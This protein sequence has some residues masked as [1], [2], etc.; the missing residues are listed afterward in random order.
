[1]R[2]T[3]HLCLAVS[4]LVLACRFMEAQQPKRPQI[5]GVEHI[6]LWAHDYEKSRAFYG[7]FLGF[8]ESYSLKNADGSPAVTFFKINDRQYI[9]L[10][11]EHEAGTDRLNHMGLLTDDA[12]GMRAYLAAKGYTVPAQI[13]KGRI[14][15]LN[16]TFQDPEGHAVEVVQYTPDSWPLREKGKHLPVSRIS[17]RMMHVGIIVTKLHDEMVFYTDV[18]GF[19]EFW[20]GSST[21]K[22]LSWINLKIPE[23]DDYIELMLAATAAPPDQRGSAHHLCLAVPDIAASVKTLEA[24]PARQ[25]YP[26]PIEIHLGKNRKQQS[27][28]F[29]P[30]G[31]RTELM[32]PRTIDGKPTPPS[33]APPPSPQL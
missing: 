11:P 23:G 26:K 32:E 13:K 18:L 22:T 29:D 12:E 33:D 21:G 27:N 6:S 24:R 31:T 17:D 25:D 20:R 10:S 5:L 16:F 28:F 7:S 15:T 2:F 8:E 4:F 1:M 3:N 30:D 14:G 9:Q 19:T